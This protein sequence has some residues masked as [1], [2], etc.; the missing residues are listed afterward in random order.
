MKDGS[1]TAVAVVA[2][3]AGVAV[4]GSAVIVGVVDTAAGAGSHDAVP[5]PN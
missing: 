3:F 5:K 1:L 2:A 4:V